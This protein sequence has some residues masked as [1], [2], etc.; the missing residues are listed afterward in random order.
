MK[1]GMY[2]G[3]GTITYSGGGQYVGIFSNGYPK[4]GTY[5]FPDGL[6]YAEK[7]W[8]YCDGHDRRFA[9]EV[10]S[11]IEPA[12]NCSRFVAFPK[13]HCAILLACRFMMVK[14]CTHCLKM[15]FHK[16]VLSI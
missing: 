7:K 14:I 1:D 10:W 4:S 9:T 16:S 12:D 6:E 13:S 11:R 3:K 8:L 2:H 15:H 5:F